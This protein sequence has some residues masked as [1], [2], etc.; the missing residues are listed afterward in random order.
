MNFNN[1]LNTPFFQGRGDTRKL[2]SVSDLKLDYDLKIAG[3]TFLPNTSFKTILN[4]IATEVGMSST[5]G[6]NV[7]LSNLSAVAINTTLIPGTSDGA[8]LGS[9][10]KMWSDLFLASGAVIN[11]NNGNVTLTH[12]TGALT[13]NVDLL[14]PDEVYGA[15]WNASLE[16]PTKNAIY[17][18]IE[19]LAG[20]IVDGTGAANLLAF[21]TDANTLSSSA[22]LQYNGGNLGIGPTTV[23]RLFHVEVS[24]AVF[25]AVTYGQR[26]THITS[27]TAVAPFGVG[28]E[29]EL[30][31]GAGTPIIA[32]TENFTWAD[33]TAASEDCTYSLQLI[34]AGTLETTLSIDISG[35]IVGAKSF[36]ATQNLKAGSGNNIFWDGRSSMQS[37][38]DGNLLFRDSTAATFG[39]LQ[40]GGT[41]S[42]FPALKR[43]TTILVA[44]LADDSANTNIEVL[45]DAY[46]VGWNGSSNVPTKNAIY[47][48]IESL[49]VTASGTY[50]P[51]LTPVLNIEAATP[52]TCQYMRVGSVVTVS[53]YINMDATAT[54]ATQL[55]ISLPIASDFAAVEQCAGTGYSSTIVSEGCAILGDL[56][57]N[58]A[59]MNWNTSTAASQRFFFTFTYLIV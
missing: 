28:T 16:V 40:L 37:P 21:W 30:E 34:R 19:S 58:R 45:D 29:I 14:V 49:P 8:A 44:R 13:S 4:R 3:Y 7:S 53:G 43:S 36:Y 33:A 51:T 23:D 25:D 11:F 15:G 42:S 32:A 10:T 38:V 26:L 56:T 17:D 31:N 6:A 35:N 54:G 22:T 46:A 50:T 27:G 20:T 2:I 9:T 52:S 24:D 59:E 48:K 47:D 5:T 12:S 39:L 18:K 57:N 1:K 41:T 55:G